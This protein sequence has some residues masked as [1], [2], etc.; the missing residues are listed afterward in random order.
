M[1]IKKERFYFFFC[2]NEVKVTAGSSECFGESRKFSKIDAIKTVAPNADAF[3]LSESVRIL[4]EVTA[5]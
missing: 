3:R 5:V 1:Q 2:E 4:T